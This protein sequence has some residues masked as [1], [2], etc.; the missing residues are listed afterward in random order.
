[1]KNLKSYRLFESAKITPNKEHYLDLCDILISNILDDFEVTSWVD[2]VVE[3][4]NELSTNCFWAFT[5][6]TPPNEE[7]SKSELKLSSDIDKIDEVFSL[8][9]YNVTETV[10]DDFDQQI[11]D[12]EIE[13]IVKSITGFSLE[14]SIQENYIDEVGYLCDFCFKL[15]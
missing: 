6:Y 13:S 11:K 9:V 8:C 2:E 15:K 5:Q 12:L 10:F 4:D 7:G 3:F 1:M 14:V